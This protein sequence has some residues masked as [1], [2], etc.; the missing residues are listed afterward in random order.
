MLGCQD[1]CGY[2]DWTFHYMR[3]HFGQEAI[4]T[5]CQASGTL[6]AAMP[7]ACLRIPV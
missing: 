1:F 2:Y 6:E 3:R 7:L 5:P 4:E